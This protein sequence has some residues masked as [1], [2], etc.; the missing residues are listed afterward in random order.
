MNAAVLTSFCSQA[1]AL[2]HSISD[3][4]RMLILFAL[5]DG[6]RSLAAL[7]KAIPLC[8]FDL[9]RQ[10]KTLSAE[11]II[12]KRRTYQGTAYSLELTDTNR[13]ISALNSE[14]NPGP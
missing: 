10:L 13:V 4:G 9:H 8:E 5:R 11:G 1:S 6:E 3:E 12:S 2:L 14:R 7:R